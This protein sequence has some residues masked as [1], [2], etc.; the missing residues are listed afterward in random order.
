MQENTPKSLTCLECQN[1]IPLEHEVSVNDVIE[2]PFCG[3]ELEVT[4]FGEHGEIQS[5]IV[6]EEK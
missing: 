3:I 1:T 4:G 5:V 6:E 2:C